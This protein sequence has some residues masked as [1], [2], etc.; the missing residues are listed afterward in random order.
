MLAAGGVV[1]SDADY[2]DGGMLEVEM[3]TFRVGD[4]PG[5]STE[6]TSRRVRLPAIA[7][8]ASEPAFRYGIVASPGAARTLGGAVAPTAVL[9][10]MSEP[11][12]DATEARIRSTLE[13]EQLRGY[14][15]VERGH[16]GTVGLGLL[17]VVVATSVVTLGAAGIAT[18]LAQ[19]DSRPDH[20]TLS[21]VGAAPRLRRL[22]AASQAGLLSLLG[23]TL[24]AAAGLVP[25]IAIIAADAS[26]RLTMPWLTL[27]A[28][29]LG[30]PLLAALCA[31]LFVR[32]RLPLERRI[33]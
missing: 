9:A 32:S 12:D 25:G 26:L 5:G 1:V 15:Y 30:L 28:L 3:T 17:A 2:V 27:A 13:R 19:A 31:G 22:L 8:P 10:T 23:S 14:V 18:G 11:V 24:G 33:A 16:V 6:P 21:A 20:A 29:V 4:T 7:L